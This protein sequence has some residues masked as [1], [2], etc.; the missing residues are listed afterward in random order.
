MG[1]AKNN[2]NVMVLPSQRGR[3][4]DQ[5]MPDVINVP[6]FPTGPMQLLGKV[7]RKVAYDP[8]ET[9]A[10]E[11]QLTI[12]GPPNTKNVLVTIS[13]VGLSSGA[14]DQPA[15]DIGSFMFQ[16]E[17]LPGDLWAVAAY[18]CSASG[19]CDWNGEITLDILCFG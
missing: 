7:T 10:G 19:P 5:P 12:K 18:L 13:G 3:E 4:E 9:A 11:F 15:T 6:A 17:K 16:V 1:A 8:G 14:P 2:N